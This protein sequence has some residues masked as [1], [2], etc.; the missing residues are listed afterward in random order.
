MH[1]SVARQCA[2][3]LGVVGMGGNTKLFIVRA[4]MRGLLYKEIQANISPNGV[5][6]N[7]DVELEDNQL[8]AKPHSKVKP[9]NESKVKL[10]K[11]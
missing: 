6:H 1:F 10:Q 8:T 5:W 3:L 7:Y 2:P 4:W 9:W 11:Q